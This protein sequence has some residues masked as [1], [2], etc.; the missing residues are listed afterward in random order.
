MTIDNLSLLQLSFAV[1]LVISVSLAVLLFMIKI[2]DTEYT[3]RLRRTKSV[4]EVCFITCGVIFCFSVTHD[5]LNHDHLFS[6]VMLLSVTAVTAVTF[7]YALTNLV[8]ENYSLDTFLVNV[9]IVTGLSIWTGQSVLAGR[10]TATIILISVYAVYHLIQCI[11]QMRIF[12]EVVVKARKRL[13]EYY[14]NHIEYN[15]DWIVFCYVITMVIEILIFVFLLLPLSWRFV[16]P[17]L[18]GV[19]MLY[20]TGNFISFLSRHEVLLDSVAHK[21][22][23][24]RGDK[25]FKSLGFTFRKM[26][27][28][29]EALRAETSGRERNRFNMELRRLSVNIDKWVKEKKYREMDMDRDEIVEDLRTTKEVFTAFFVKKGIDFRTW[30]TELRINDAKEMLLRDKDVSVNVISERC[31]FSDRSNF[32]RQFTRIVGCSPKMWRESDGIVNESQG[33]TGN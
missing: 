7:S 9:L 28:V 13:D 14:D 17:A 1:D 15:L 18:Y 22:I 6:E 12:K 11:M 24:K 16:F 32:H 31:G 8:S 4:I 25:I 2:P 10:E 20:F 33:G 30:R 3:K 23:V 26:L 19:F 29:Q 5:E 21:E 27:P